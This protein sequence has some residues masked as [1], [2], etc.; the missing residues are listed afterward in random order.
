MASRQGAMVDSPSRTGTT[1]ET[2]GWVSVCA[3]GTGAQVRAY[4]RPDRPSVAKRFGAVGRGDA[5]VVF[6]HVLGVGGGEDI[7]DR[8]LGGRFGLGRGETAAGRLDV[9]DL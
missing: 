1:T 3:L 6:E 7:L 2:K 8:D 5:L 4:A 9:A